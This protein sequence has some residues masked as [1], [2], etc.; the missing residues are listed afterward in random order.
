MF[1]KF[2][3][4]CLAFNILI[5]YL[6]LNRKVKP[7]KLQIP[8]SKMENFGELIKNRRSTRKFA[9]EELKQEEVVALLRSALISPTS[10]RTNCWQFVAVDDKEVLGK[11]AHC[12]EHGANFIADAAL[13][14][15]VLA[16]PLVSDVWIEDASIASIMIQLQAEDMGLGTCW[17]QVRE[18]FTADGLSSD[19]YVRDILDIPLQLQVLSIIAIGHKGMER[20]PFDED[21]LQWEKVHI[22][23]YGNQ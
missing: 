22:N 21:N 7:F 23:K 11:L 17:A 14:I 2:I 19:D 5:V 20:K 16:D 12:K 3:I 13:A 18:R 6:C 15:V 8:Y 4:F 1:R 10:K 9:A